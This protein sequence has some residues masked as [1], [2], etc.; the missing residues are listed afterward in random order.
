VSELDLS[1][2]LRTAVLELGLEDQIQLPHAAQT[3]EQLLGS[4]NAVASLREV[5]ESLLRGGR[6]RLY[7]G[8]WGDA[9][10]AE[11]TTADALSLLADPDWYVFDLDNPREE[12]LYFVNVENLRNQ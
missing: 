6:I 8:H 12:R 3:A 11:L 4:T 7:R 9:D 10:P 1:P 2:D 5:L